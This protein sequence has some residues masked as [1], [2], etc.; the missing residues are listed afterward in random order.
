MI[1]EARVNILFEDEDIQDDRQIVNFINED[2]LRHSNGDVRHNIPFND[3]ADVMEKKDQNKFLNHQCCSVEFDK[4]CCI[5]EF[6][7]I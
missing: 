6:G 1:K 5:T 4:L 2:E 3:D 7:T